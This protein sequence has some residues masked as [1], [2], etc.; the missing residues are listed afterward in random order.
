MEVGEGS[1][2]P[3]V[4]QL[5]LACHIEGPGTRDKK[6]DKILGCALGMGISGVRAEVEQGVHAAGLS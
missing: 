5:F 4:Y 1:I 3:A 6:N 2:A